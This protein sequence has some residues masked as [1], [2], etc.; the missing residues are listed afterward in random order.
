MSLNESGSAC[1]VTDHL[2][3]NR[4]WDS[5]KEA[6]CKTMGVTDQRNAPAGLRSCFKDLPFQHLT[7]F[8]LS[9]SLDCIYTGGHFYIGTY[10]TLDFLRNVLTVWN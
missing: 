6:A 5:I 3:G 2:T 10:S 9:L 7:C 8:G 4:K 1:H